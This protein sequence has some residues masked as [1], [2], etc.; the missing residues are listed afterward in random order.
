MVI[1]HVT[2][3][4]PKAIG[5][6]ATCVFN[7]EKEQEKQGHKVFI[8]TPNCRDILEK[9]NLYRFGVR[10]VSY[11][12]DNVTIRRILSLFFFPW[13]SLRVIRRIKPDIIHS[14][15]ADLGFLISFWARLFSIPLINTCHSL[16]FPHHFISGLK[17]YP[18]YLCLRFGLFNAIVAVDSVSLEYL[19]THKI[20]H[21]LYVPM[22][23]VDTNEFDRIRNRSQNA[24][25]SPLATFLFVGRLDKFKGLYYLI[26]AAECVKKERSDFQVVIIGSGP[27]KESLEA[28]AKKLDVESHVKFKPAITA[29]ELLIEEYCRADIY[30]S[31]SVL[32]TF[33][34]GVVDAWAARLAVISSPVGVAATYGKDRENML[35]VPARNVSAIAEAMNILLENDDLRQRIASCGWELAK[36][37]FDWE[38]IVKNLVKLYNRYISCPKNQVCY[39]EN[40]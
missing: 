23:G 13:K 15:S 6:D 40:G 5:G 32:E 29:R 7:L 9:N 31:P 38:M 30:V 21:C 24:K 27:E 14:H 11:R 2:K 26:A 39:G 20:R 12:W 1:L 19:H 37:R 33:S 36:E 17:R 4:Y 16:S 35:I 34:F 28:Y 25:K 10:D 22:L 18:E 8:L 3:K